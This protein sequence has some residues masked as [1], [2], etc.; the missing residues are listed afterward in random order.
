MSDPN[1][2]FWCPR[3]R[4]QSL[5]VT[6][7]SWKPLEF[8]SRWRLVGQ[9]YGLKIPFHHYHCHFVI[10]VA[11]VLHQ[12]CRR[13][14]HSKT[15]LIDWIRSFK[16]L[17]PR[18]SSRWGNRHLRS[19]PKDRGSATVSSIR[20]TSSTST[21]VRTLTWGGDLVRGG[22]V[23]VAAHCCP[24]PFDWGPSLGPSTRSVY[25]TSTDLSLLWSDGN[26]RLIWREDYI[27]TDVTTSHFMGLFPD[28]MWHFFR[29][30]FLRSSTI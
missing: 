23:G 13:P 14:V 25:A 21:R 18:R 6:T 8:I 29:V 22:A 11:I 17:P 12:R 16:H 15:W 5:L 7:L 4:G 27:E 19:T 30:F 1:T 10:G 28:D 2:S 20:R 3:R 26:R 9:T 24:C